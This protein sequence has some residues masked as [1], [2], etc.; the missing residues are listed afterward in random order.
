M[1][2]ELKKKLIEVQRTELTEYYTYKKLAEHEKNPENRAILNEIAE[3]ELRHYKFWEKQTGIA[4]RHSGFLVMIYYVISRVLG[5]TFTIKLMEHKEQGAQVNYQEIAREIPEASE[6]EADENAHEQKL[7]GMIN[8]ERLHYIGSVVL[9]LNDALVELTGTLAGLSL[10]L[11]NSRLVAVAGLITGIAA[12]L[13]MA[14]SEYLSTKSEKTSV[15]N[16]V[17]A[18][19]VTGTAYVATVFVLILPFLLLTNTV[20]ALGLTL[21][22]VLMIIACFTYY[23]SVTHDLSFSR[24]FAEMAGIS[25]AVAM[26]TFLIGYFIQRFWNIEV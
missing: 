7:I 8:E 26:I 2:E 21:V 23:I 25:V 13:S 24:K 4:V 15:K 1:V 22:T 5:L 12:S 17:R 10:S 9:G 20:V 18:S 19:V 14:A 16:P 3:D 11:R 6:I